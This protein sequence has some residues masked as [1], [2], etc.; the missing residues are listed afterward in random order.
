MTSTQSSEFQWP[1]KWAD[2]E[3]AVLDVETTGLDSASDRVIEVGIVHFVGGEE[4][5]SY[6]QLVDPGCPVP[7][8]VVELTGITPDDLE[9]KPAFEE[10]AHEVHRRLQNVGIGAYNLSF[11]QGFLVAE[12]E[13]SGLKWPEEAPIFDP[14]IFARQFFKNMRR[15]NLGTIAKALDIE[16]K[17]A[18]RATEDARATGH[19]LY[20]FADRLPEGLQDLQLLQGQW[21]AAQAQEMTWM[22]RSRGEDTFTQALGAQ[23]AGLGPGY[24]YGEE[25]DPLRALYSTVPEAPPRE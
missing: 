9:G 19:V 3:I 12:L 10:V 25:A 23:P 11:D 14:L 4:V 15:K 7:Q 21:A 17:E 5:D 18:H 1:K 24:I 6:N 2:L 8:E 13:R 20:A 22:R 16:L